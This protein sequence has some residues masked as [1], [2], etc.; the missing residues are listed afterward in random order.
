MGGWAALCGSGD[1]ARTACVSGGVS[2][3][4]TDRRL[5]HMAAGVV[6]ADAGATELNVDLRVVM[7][8]QYFTA[9]IF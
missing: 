7:L 4:G 9:V 6:L 5:L 3:V 1:T 8:L 2:S